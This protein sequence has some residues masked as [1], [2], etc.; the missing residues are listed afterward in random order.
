[1]KRLVGCLVQWQYGCYM[2][3]TVTGGIWPCDVG[4]AL[5]RWPGAQ[6]R[7]RLSSLGGSSMI[8]KTYITGPSYTVT[9]PPQPH[10]RFS[11]HLL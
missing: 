8:D 10:S 1:M 7:R 2:L 3:C 9:L 5:P 11:R 6:T 4:S